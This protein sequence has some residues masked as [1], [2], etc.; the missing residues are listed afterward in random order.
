[1]TMPPEDVSKK[2][3]SHRGARRSSYTSVVNVDQIHN[4]TSQEVIHITA[5]KLKL[6]LMG[7][8]DCLAK[9]NA[10]HVPLSL[11]AS[12][13]VVFFTST[14]KD[15]LGVKADQLQVGFFIFAVG[16]LIWLVRAVY[17]ARKSMSVEE[18]IEV[19]KNK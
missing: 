15:F 6:A 12:A 13:V 19:I 3:T 5:D 10:W 18:L 17:G 16:C 9:K 8:L 4:N 11:F 14:F 1:M 7:Y 2:G